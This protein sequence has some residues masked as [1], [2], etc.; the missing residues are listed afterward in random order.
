MQLIRK[1]NKGFQ[2][3]LCAIDT[4]SKYTWVAPLRDKRN[5]IIT[6][7]YIMKE[8]LLLLRNLLEPEKQNL[9]VYD[10]NNKRRVY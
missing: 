8:N 2:F 4:Y 7:A 6:K 1:S 10:F 5:I 9:E 3:L